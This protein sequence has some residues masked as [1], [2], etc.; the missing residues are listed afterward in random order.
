VA[1]PINGM[2]PPGGWHYFQG[3]VRL[4]S[5]ALP[6]LYR[7]VQNY[8]AENALP[9]G[10]VEGDVNE[11]LCGRNPHYCHGVDSLTINM[12]SVNPA[13]AVEELMNDI[14]TWAKNILASNK[15]YNLVDDAEAARRARICLHCPKNANWR[16]GCGPCINSTD[17]LC[18]SVRQA[19]DIADTPV[20]GG[21][22]IL[23]HDN[24]SAVF[25]EKDLFNDNAELPNE[26]W[27]KQ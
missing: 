4:E 15:P 7:V 26:C 25:L 5:W 16:G 18:A 27:I 20:L 10:D 11:Q 23:R 24:R 13:T 21:C 2:I 22:H 14:Q 19:R 3:D 1:K 12:V 6:E 17:R 9:S 8:R